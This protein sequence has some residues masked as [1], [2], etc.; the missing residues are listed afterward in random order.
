MATKQD[1]LASDYFQ[2]YIRLAPDE[3]MLTAL[4]KN[5][6][7]FRRML[8]RIP[9]KKIDRAY[10]EGKWTIKEMLQHIIDT[11]RVFTYRALTFA[12][13]DSAALPGFDENAW[14]EN[15]QAKLRNWKEMVEE[16]KLLRAANERLFATFDDGQLR[17]IGLASGKEVNVLALGYLLSGHVEHHINILKERYLNK[18]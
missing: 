7:N 1:T 18:K 4:Q 6:R 9:R 2:N 13:K 15:S 14:A 17:S 16:F 5:T 10:A 3:D 11:E 12:R 8:K